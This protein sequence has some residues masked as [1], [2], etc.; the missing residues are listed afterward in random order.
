VFY[1]TET[2]SGWQIVPGP[3]PNPVGSDHFV[4]LASNWTAPVT[5]PI[6]LPLLGDVQPSKYLIYVN[7]Q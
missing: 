3:S 4:D 5:G 1:G 2:L 6:N 7:P